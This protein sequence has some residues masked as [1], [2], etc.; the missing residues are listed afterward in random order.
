MVVR[1]TTILMA[2]PGRHVVRTHV[3][4]RMG[5]PAH[6]EQ[7]RE[8]ECQRARLSELPENDDQHVEEHGQLELVAE[9]VVDLHDAFRP[10]VVVECT[11]REVDA[12]GGE[13]P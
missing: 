4:V 11:A 8:H 9:V 12:A 10:G 3:D 1:R 5:N 2:A 7:P 13:S 6:D